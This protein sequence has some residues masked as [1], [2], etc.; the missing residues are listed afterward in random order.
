MEPET[1]WTVASLQSN[2]NKKLNHLWEALIFST[3]VFIYFLSQSKM[4]HLRGKSSIL[5]WL[6]KLAL[7]LFS[8]KPNQGL[9]RLRCCGMIHISDHKHYPDSIHWLMFF[10]YDFM[11][12]ECFHYI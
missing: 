6:K 8:W 3:I 9:K 5:L 4:T 1:Q 2:T 10:S 7:T 11:F 12:L